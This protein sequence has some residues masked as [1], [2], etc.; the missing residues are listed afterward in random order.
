ASVSAVI[1]DTDE[2]KRTGR[3]VMAQGNQISFI[4]RLLKDDYGVPGKYIKE[5]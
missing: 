5:V 2:T 3:V 1:N 4:T